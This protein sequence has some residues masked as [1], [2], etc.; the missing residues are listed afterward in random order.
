M[1]VKEIIFFFTDTIFRKKPDEYK[2][3]VVRWA[4]R[5][6]K[7]L[8]YTVQGLSQHGTMVQSAAMTFYTLISIVPIVALVFAVVKGFGLLDG[9]V[10]RIEEEL[11]QKCTLIATGGMAQFVTPLCKRE[12]HLE[13]ELLLKG[14]LAIYKKNKK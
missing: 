8:F 7:L 3:P 10:E 4:A 11:G 9:L 5:Q 14:L 13:K 1:T 2:N 12:I 6:Y